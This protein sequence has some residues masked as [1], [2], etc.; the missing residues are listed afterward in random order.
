MD[1]I[2]IGV[3]IAK[4]VFQLGLMLPEKLFCAGACAV[5]RPQPFLLPCRPV[6]WGWKRARPR[7]FGFVSSP[8]SGMT[9]ALCRL[10]TS[11]PT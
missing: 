11:N 10:A 8:H 1:E 6:W 2:T 4:H 7:T 5:A 3:D 9:C